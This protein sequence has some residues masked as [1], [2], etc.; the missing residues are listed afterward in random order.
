[1][2]DGP[3]LKDGD[4]GRPAADVHQAHPQLLL[5]FGEHRL[6]RGQ[7]LE[8]DVGDVET[9]PV[10]ALDDVLGAG[11]RAGHDVH[12][13]LEARPGDAQRLS[14]ARLIVD[15]EL[16]REHVDDLTV[17]GD[18]DRLG[19]LDDS[20]HVGFADLTVLERH[21]APAP[22]ALDVASSDA[23]VDV[24]D[25]G[26]G[27]RLGLVDGPLNR[28]HR[29]LD[30]H[31]HALAESAGGVRPNAD[32]VDALVGQLAHDGAD[33]GRADVEA[34]E[35]LPTLLV[36]HDAS[37]SPFSRDAKKMFTGDRP[38]LRAPRRAAPPPTSDARG[39]RGG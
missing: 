8:H 11:H 14:D 29:R 38:D 16:L 34:D 35:N 24:G 12:L 4:V 3:V 18:V 10:G 2:D 37:R 32:D 33:L 25:L 28:L 30:V 19:L 36:C 17:Q 31:H 15:D 9:G 5:F 23:G 22:E 7:R 1:V 27:H 20:G 6:A 26:A 13:R 39:C 21:H